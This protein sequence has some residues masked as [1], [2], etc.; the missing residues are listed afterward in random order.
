VDE[1]SKMITGDFNIVKIDFFNRMEG[2]RSEKVSFNSED[3][4]N[5]LR[6][7]SLSAARSVVGSSTMMMC[8]PAEKLQ[9]RTRLRKS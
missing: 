7:S 1:E 5:I 8:L 6:D 4:K 9:L 2:F 3:P